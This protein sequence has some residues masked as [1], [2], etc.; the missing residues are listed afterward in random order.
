MLITSFVRIVKVEIEYF[1]IIKDSILAFSLF[2]IVGG[3]EAIIAFP[4]NFAIVVVL[5]LLASV[6]VPL[7]MAT[8]HFLIHNPFVSKSNW[9]KVFMGFGCFLLSPGIPIILLNEYE[10]AKEKLK[11]L[12]RNMDK[13]IMNQLK[14]GRAIKNQ[15]VSFVKIELGRENNLRNLF[16]FLINTLHFS[17]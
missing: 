2:R 8:L 14:N 1:D 10:A 9:K 3:F 4:S 5:C 17:V 16:K 7:I 12:A 11:T 6:F 15:W 13:N